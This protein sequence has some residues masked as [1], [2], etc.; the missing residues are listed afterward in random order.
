MAD[1]SVT[2]PNPEDDLRHLTLSFLVDDEAR[3]GTIILDPSV[4]G[5]ET[6]TL[7]IFLEGRLVANLTM[8]QD[9]RIGDIELLDLSTQ[10]PGLWSI[11][12]PG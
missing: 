3:L 9:G 6:R 1:R 4:R 2:D 8:A 11:P 12:P 10:M 5:R 7:P